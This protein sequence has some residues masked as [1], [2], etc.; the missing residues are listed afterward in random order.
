MIRVALPRKHLIEKIKMSVK[1]FV[2]FYNNETSHI[3]FSY[4]ETLE[5]V[6]CI[7]TACLHFID[8]F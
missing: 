5:A 2:Y 1:F 3:L 6:H 7:K 8:S 4:T